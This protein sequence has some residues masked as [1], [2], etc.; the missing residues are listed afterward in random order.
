M[1]FTAIAHD[2]KDKTFI[3]TNNYTFILCSDE[4]EQNKYCMFDDKMT[5]LARDFADHN[6]QSDISGTK[7][8]RAYFQTEKT[9]YWSKLFHMYIWQ[10]LARHNKVE[11]MFAPIK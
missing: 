3:L 5:D 2:I 6:V 4:G 9:A 8:Q 10:H 1:E 7:E 11:T